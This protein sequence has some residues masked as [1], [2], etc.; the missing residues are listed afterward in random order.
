VTDYGGLGG[1]WGGRE[2]NHGDEFE[3]AAERALGKRIRESDDVACALWCA[4]A[5]SDWT[6]KAS[7]DTAGYSF[8]AAGDLVAAIRGKGDY[9]DWYCC[10]GCPAITDE[11]E[12]AMAAE[13][14]TWEPTP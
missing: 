4:L 6:H 9:M 11:I 5:N 8:R 3:N 10:G 2:R 14:W 13:G 7:G 1:V 12:K